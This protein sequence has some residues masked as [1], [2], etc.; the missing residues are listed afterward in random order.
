M[1]Y[2]QSVMA[3]VPLQLNVQGRFFLLDSTGAESSVTVTLLRGGSPIFGQ[4][5]GAKRGLK[6]GIEG[7]FDGVRIEAGGDA[8]IRFFATFENVSISTTDGAQ[9]E[10]SNSPENPLSVDVQNATL[11]VS[12]VTLKSSGAIT[13]S[14]AAPGAVVG[15]VKAA[16]QNRRSLRIKNIGA[17]D[18]AIGGAAV[19]FATAAIVL[20]PGDVW[21]ED[22]GAGAAWY[23]VTLSGAGSLAIQEVQ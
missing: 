15:Q 14:T 2:E 1:L 21:V 12:E 13:D 5:P 23:A 6:I 7:G 22:D 11:S 17:V 3:G 10:V 4:I 20:A 18:V 8:V 16:N 19:V 9:V